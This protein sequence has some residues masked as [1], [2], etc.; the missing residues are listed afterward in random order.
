MLGQIGLPGG[1]FGCGYGPAN[2]MG[3]GALRHPGPTLPQGTNPVSDFI[4][5]ARIADM[6]LQPGERFSYNAA[7]HRYPD[8]RLGYWPGA[9]PF[10]HHQSLTPLRLPRRKPSTVV[11]SHQYS[12]PPPR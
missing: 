9:N 6:M 1:G 11:F 3:S 10:R 2:L 5:V 8:I 4:P 12:T 7:D